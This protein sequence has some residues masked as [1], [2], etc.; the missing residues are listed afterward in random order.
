M[1]RNE[2]HRGNILLRS[3]QRSCGHTL[4]V[5]S[6]LMI[7]F[8]RV[9]TLVLEMARSE[10]RTLLSLPILAL[11]CSDMAKAQRFRNK[12]SIKNAL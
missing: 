8:A 3:D 10:V 4:T 7:M 1:E 9:M 6:F 12:R 5:L 11:L 2:E